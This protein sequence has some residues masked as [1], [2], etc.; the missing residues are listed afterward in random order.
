MGQNV[1]S[2]GSVSYSENTLT[3]EIEPSTLGSIALTS[4]NGRVECYWDGNQ[5]VCN[6]V[7]FAQADNQSQSPSAMSV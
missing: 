7:T 3:I 2:Y 6:S 1:G 5:W 4:A